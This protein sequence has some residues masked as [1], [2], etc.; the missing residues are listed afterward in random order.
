MR[1]VTFKEALQHPGVHQVHGYLREFI[2]V[3]RGK[4]YWTIS[5]EKEVRTPAIG[6]GRG[7]HLMSAGFTFDLNVSPKGSTSERKLLLCDTP[8]PSSPARSTG[9]ST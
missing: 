7:D 9:S 1:T 8:R 3:R 6:E 2:T 5:G 4:A